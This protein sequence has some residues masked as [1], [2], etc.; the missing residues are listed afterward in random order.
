MTETAQYDVIVP[1]LLSA[2]LIVATVVIHMLGLIVLMGLLQKRSRQIRPFLSIPR[3]GLFII[4][5]VLGLVVIH[6][7]EIWLYALVYLALGEF[8]TLE[9]ALYYSISTF[10]TAG[11]GD[12]VQDSHWRL[13]GAMESFNGFLL[14]GWST[15]FLVSVIGRLRSMETEWLDALRQKPD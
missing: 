7:V 6:S 11:F 9:L 5:I 1:L 10:T 2:G 14:I 3:Q 13:V 12:I 8:P 15:A 4:L